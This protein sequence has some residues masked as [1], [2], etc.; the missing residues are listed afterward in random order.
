ML[1]AARRPAILADVQLIRYRLQTQFRQLLAKSGYPYATPMMGK[2][3]IEED[4]PQ[5]IGLTF[6]IS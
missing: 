1:N 4:H 6:V 5:F 2:C 3:V